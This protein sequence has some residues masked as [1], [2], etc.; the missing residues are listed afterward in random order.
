MGWLQRLGFGAARDQP[1]LVELRESFGGFAPYRIMRRFEGLTAAPEAAVEVALFKRWRAG[2]GERLGAQSKSAFELARDAL[3]LS[4]RLLVTQRDCELGVADSIEDGLLKE[5]MSALT[6]GLCNCELA[7][8]VVWM[9]LTDAGHAVHPFETGSDGECGGGNHLLLYLVDDDGAAFVD[10]WSDVPLVHIENFLPPLRYVER[11]RDRKQIEALSGRR[12]P[13]VPSYA[14]LGE[15]VTRRVH[16]LYPEA[17]FRTGA[18]R[19]SFDNINPRWTLEV[20]DPGP[21]EPDAVPTYWREYV[22]LRQ[23]HIW[24]EL[25]DAGAAYE[26][27]SSREGINPTLRQVVQVLARRQARPWAERG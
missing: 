21:L 17:A 16:G 18:L 11:R 25:E 23:R 12:P 4:R 9:V 26:A 5:A 7:N 6:S 15:G 13:G 27:F 10:A 22:D 2:L 14:E 3:A 1:S 24:G 8:L 20:S 19:S